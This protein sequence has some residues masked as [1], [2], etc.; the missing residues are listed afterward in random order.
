MMTEH[1]LGKYMV[2]QWREG[3]RHWEVVNRSTRH[4]LGTISRYP[5]WRQWVFS[6]DTFGDLVFSASC[7]RE[8]AGFL[9]E[10]NAGRIAPLIA[11]ARET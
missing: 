1:D 10:L 6:P 3:H 9:T 8:I 5:Q 2:A 11:E 7:L 4:S